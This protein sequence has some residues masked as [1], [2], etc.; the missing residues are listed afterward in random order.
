[1]ADELIN[2]LVKLIQER[3]PWLFAD[4]GFKVIDYSYDPKFFGNC[5]VTLQSESLRLS[6]MRDRGFC[7]A[8]LASRADPKKSYELGFLMLA[9]QDTRPDIG[10]EGNAAL[11]KDNW[12]LLAN[13][14][15]PNLAETKREYERRKEVSR[16]LFVHQLNQIKLTPRGRIN[17]FK[18]T[19][20]GRVLFRLLRFVE[21]ALILWALYTVFNHREMR[22]RG[23]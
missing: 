17:M 22:G 15:G 6:F 19:A 11:L 8:Q 7:S 10:F 2:P 3:L 1:M 5:I 18:K 13:A 16:E 23:A 14:L 9:L 12:A 21:V 4:F 20:F